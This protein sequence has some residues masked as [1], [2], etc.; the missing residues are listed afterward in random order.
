[1]SYDLCKNYQD[2]KQFSASRP[3]DLE[4]LA[5]LAEP[6]QRQACGMELQGMQ[7]CTHHQ[8]VHSPLES[9]ESKESG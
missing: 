3:Q 8:L 6:A 9:K 7:D 1:V 4:R 5:D 2:W